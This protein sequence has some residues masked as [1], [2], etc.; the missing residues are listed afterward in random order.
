MTVIKV[1]TA[2]ELRKEIANIPEILQSEE[3][4][5]IRVQWREPKPNGKVTFTAIITEERQENGNSKE[6]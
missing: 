2:T 6:K 1:V 3:D 5:K 4:G